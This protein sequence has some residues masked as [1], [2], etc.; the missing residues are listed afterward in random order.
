MATTVSNAADPALPADARMTPLAFLRSALGSL[1]TAMTKA[2]ACNQCAHR[3][4]RNR[5]SRLWACFVKDSGHVDLELALLL[6]ASPGMDTEMHLVEPHRDRTKYKAMEAKLNLELGSASKVLRDEETPLEINPTEAGEQTMLVVPPTSFESPSRD[7]AFE[8]DSREACLMLTPSKP[9]ACP[10]S[11]NLWP[12]TTSAEL[13]P[14]LLPSPPAQD[15]VSPLALSPAACSEASSPPGSSSGPPC[16]LRWD[17]EFEAEAQAFSRRVALHQVSWPSPA[18]IDVEDH[19]CRAPDIPTFEFFDRRD[20]SFRVLDGEVLRSVDHMT[21]DIRDGGS[22]QSSSSVAVFSPGR[23][24]DTCI[25]EEPPDW[26]RYKIA[27]FA[28]REAVRYDRRRRRTMQAG[29]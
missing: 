5:G 11:V 24:G 19:L 6:T 3:R 8:I 18:K 27:S 4:T 28:C 25:Y 7:C 14:E 15:D 21:G 12:L 23:V 13:S 9:R 1:G 26:P 20:R 22:E 16:L 29:G 2:W 10:T 17:Q